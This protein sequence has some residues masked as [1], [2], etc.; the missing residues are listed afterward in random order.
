MLLF[1]VRVCVIR[2]SRECCYRFQTQDP[3]AL[4]TAIAMNLR[5]VTLRARK[6]TEAGIGSSRNNPIGSSR[7]QPR[8]SFRQTDCFAR[9][10]RSRRPDGCN[11][12][13]SPRRRGLT[14][15]RV[16]Y[17]E[18]V[19][20]RD[21]SC[22]QTSAPTSAPIGESATGQIFATVLFVVSVTTLSVTGWARATDSDAID[23]AAL[24]E[25]RSEM[26]QLREERKHDREEIRS[27][28]RKS[29][30]SK[31]KIQGSRPPRSNCRV[32]IRS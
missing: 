31:R 6:K 11:E 30:N 7:I 15:R 10:S 18:K 24:K 4:G 5:I 17:W 22:S 12:D 9:D 1:R 28:E 16:A 26:R 21:T 8:A 25:I 2:A 20:L 3:A 23:A 19:G 29:S 27:L 14:T 32:P 13:S